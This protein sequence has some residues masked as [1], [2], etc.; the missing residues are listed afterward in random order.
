MEKKLECKGCGKHMAI[1]RDAKVRKGMVVYCAECAGTVDKMLTQK[2]AS[3]AHDL[4]EF[5][6][7]LFGGH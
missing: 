4:P 2:T 5:M 3:A 1:L 7:G 6:R